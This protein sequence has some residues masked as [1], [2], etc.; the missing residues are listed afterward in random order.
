MTS[1]SSFPRPMDE[2]ALAKILS[3]LND[4]VRVDKADRERTS[5]IVSDAK[6]GRSMRQ[7]S[8]DLGVN[9]SS[10]SRILSGKVDSINKELLAK[11]S[12]CS[13]ADSHKTLM[14]LIDAQGL[15]F[16]QDVPK[17]ISK[18]TNTCRRILADELMIRDYSVTYGNTLQPPTVGHEI[19]DFVFETN[20]LSQSTGRWMFDVKLIPD[21]NVQMYISRTMDTF[22]RY[23]AYYYCGGSADRITMIINQQEMFDILKRRYQDVQIPNEISVILISIE[24]GCIMDEFILPTTDGHVP[25]M[26]FRE[27]VGNHEE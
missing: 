21:G 18:Y 24:A 19:F 25:K 3:R 27:E 7:F 22:S 17:A 11:I 8:E 1:N 26:L 9:V 20:A 16:R 4:T 2:E 23:M 6:G 14:A 10:I 5:R 15:A 13:A 12:V